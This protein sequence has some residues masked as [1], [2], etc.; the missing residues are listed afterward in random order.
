MARGGGG[1]QINLLMSDERE[2]WMSGQDASKLWKILNTGLKMYLF[3][4]VGMLC[5]IRIVIA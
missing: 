4:L 5:I 1:E 3:D 2:D